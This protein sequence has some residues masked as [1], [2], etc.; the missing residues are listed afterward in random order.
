MN[1]CTVK[2]APEESRPCCATPAPEGA[3]TVTPPA[4]PLEITMTMKFANATTPEQARQF[5]CACGASIACGIA[6]CG[7]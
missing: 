2:C 7:C 5:A 6:T 4:R 1:C 3:A